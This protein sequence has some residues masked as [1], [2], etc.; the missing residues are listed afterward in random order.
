MGPRNS[1]KWE[2]DKLLVAF[3]E[4]LRLKPNVKDA[5]ALVATEFPDDVPSEK[6]FRQSLYQRKHRDDEFAEAWTQAW[7]Q[8][9][10]ALVDELHRRA[11]GWTEKR[12]DRWGNEYEEFKHSDMLL[13]EAVRAHRAQYRTNMKIDT[14]R[15]LNFQMVLPGEDQSGEVYDHAP[16]AIE[17]EGADDEG[18]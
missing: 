5:V 13:L 15:A 1:S 17:H 10:D 2:T 8:G 9:A 4:A 12:V 18:D 6:A 16:G 7:D 3:I 11:M 14:P